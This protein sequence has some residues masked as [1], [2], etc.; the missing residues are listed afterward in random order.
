VSQGQEGNEHARLAIGRGQR[1]HWNE[2]RIA[3]RE[4][5]DARQKIEGHIGIRIDPEASGLL[6]E[7][8]T[9][10]Q[11]AQSHQ[12]RVVGQ[13]ELSQIGQA[14][15][16][17]ERFLAESENHEASQIHHL[18]ACRGDRSEQRLE[19]VV[20]QHAVLPGVARNTV[21]GEVVLRDPAADPLVEVVDRE[22]KIGGE[23]DHH[24][25]T[26]AR[27]EPAQPDLLPRRHAAILAQ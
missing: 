9:D 19:Q 23:P 15:R 11:D 6:A 24:R 22:L 5:E 21:N 1:G 26:N 12:G 14:E 13:P 2:P 10:H 16:E 3:S 4:G 8:H 27:R 18:R 7:D 17:D 20:G 25:Q